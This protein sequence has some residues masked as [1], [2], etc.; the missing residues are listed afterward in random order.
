MVSAYSFDF[1]EGNREKRAEK[2]ICKDACKM[3]GVLCP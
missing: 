1:M 3:D 2:N